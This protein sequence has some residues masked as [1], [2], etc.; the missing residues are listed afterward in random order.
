MLNII[1]P[2]FDDASE[3]NHN[4]YGDLPLILQTVS[5]RPI[6]AWALSHIDPLPTEKRYYVISTEQ[7]IDKHHIDKLLPLYTDN[8]ITFVRLKQNTQGMPCSILMAMD[9]INE[10]EPVLVSSVDQYININLHKHLEYF[11]ANNSDAGCIGFQ[12]V[13]P[14]WSYAELSD[15]NLVE[16]VA[17][18]IPISKNALTSTYYFSSARKMNEAIMLNILRGKKFEEKYYL[19]ACLNELIIKG[20]K[21]LYS[22]MEA[23][24]Y[25]NFYSKE[26]VIEFAKYLEEQSNRIKHLTYRYSELFNAKD[27]QSLKQLFLPEVTLE[28]SFTPKISGFKP[29]VNFYASLFKSVKILSFEPYKIAIV[30]QD[31]SMIRFK[32]QLDEEYYEGVDILRF[33]SMKLFSISAYLHK[34]SKT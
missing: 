3:V 18:K 16:R 4:N 28:D 11:R 1:L 6:I 5:D 7:Y 12:S 24:D 23:S 26:K 25:I 20:K 22:K 8:E 27:I 34:R 14:K 31:S 17:E 29:V 19:S 15:N 32:L 33:R 13:H 30:D 2:I 9:L 21:V 10:N